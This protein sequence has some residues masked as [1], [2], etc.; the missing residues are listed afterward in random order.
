MLFKKEEEHPHMRK[1]I[2]RDRTFKA[3]L[4]K[5]R[6]FQMCVGELFHPDEFEIIDAVEYE[7]G[8]LIPEDVKKLDFHLRDKKTGEP[9]WVECRFRQHLHQ[10][11]LPWTTEKQFESYKE[12][13]KANKEPVFIVVGLGGFP[14]Q[15]GEM[16][17]FPLDKAEHPHMPESKFRNYERETTK[18]FEIVGD[19]LL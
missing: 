5:S 16:F 3:N 4:K 1:K 15:P 10:N 6:K 8:Q 9:F 13:R 17:A 11:E 2:Q 7:E 19:R 12:F 18:K 14:A